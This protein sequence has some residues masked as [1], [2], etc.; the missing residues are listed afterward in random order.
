VDRKLRLFDPNGTNPAQK[1][2]KRIAMPGQ[3][4]KHEIVVA[5]GSNQGKAWGVFLRFERHDVPRKLRESS[6][7]QYAMPS[8]A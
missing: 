3:P 8:V 7:A 5:L 4:G 6:P 2:V 1:D